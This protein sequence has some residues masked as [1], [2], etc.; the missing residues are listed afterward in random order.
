LSKWQERVIDAAAAYD[1]K[2]HPEREW[3]TIEVSA[4]PERPAKTAGPASPLYL[5]FV[6]VDVDNDRGER[7]RRI[8]VLD[9][10]VTRRAFLAAGVHLPYCEFPG[11]HLNASYRTYGDSEDLC[12]TNSC[13]Y[14]AIRFCRWL[15]ASFGYLES[16]QAYIDPSQAKEFDD[17]GVAKHAPKG[18]PA[19]IDKRGFRLPTGAEWETAC[20]RQLDSTFSFG[21]DRTLLRHYAWYAADQSEKRVNPV[22]HLRPNLQGLFDMHGNVRE[23]CQDEHEGKRMNRGGGWLVSFAD[24]RSKHPDGLGPGSW[25][26]DLGFRVVQTL[27]DETLRTTQEDQ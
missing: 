26:M 7:L 13:W 14:D 19:D 20:Q 27:S 15:S 18:W 22:R 12:I 9:S 8:G 11:N 24:F 4:K 10:E 17:A 16:E 2:A 6:V 5:T 21:S 25:S 23:W 3:Y 1:P